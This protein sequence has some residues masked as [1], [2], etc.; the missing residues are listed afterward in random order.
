VSDVGQSYVLRATSE[1][2]H[3]ACRTHDGR[4]PVV[5]LVVTLPP[6]AS[7]RGPGGSADPLKIVKCK[8]F[9]LSVSSKPQ[10]AVCTLVIMVDNTG[11]CQ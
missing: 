6:V 2:I 11:A 3:D 9:A 1:V 10:K 5:N 8:S 4:V 7:F